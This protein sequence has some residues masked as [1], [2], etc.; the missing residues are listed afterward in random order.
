MPEDRRLHSRTLALALAGLLTL[1]VPVNAEPNP[2]KPT[3]PATR[4][5]PVTDTYHGEAVVDPFRWLEDGEAPEVKAWVAA[6]NAFTRRTIGEL[7]EREALRARLKALSGAPREGV[8]GRYGDRLFFTHHDGQAPQSRLLVEEKGTRRVLLDPNALSLDGTVSLDFW[9][10][11]PQGDLVAYG[12]SENGSEQSVGYVLDVLT[13]QKRPDVLPGCKYASLGWLPD[14]TGFY[15][16]RFTPDASPAGAETQKVYFHRLGTDPAK[17]PMLFSHPG[18][19]EVFLSLG[20][21]RD[22]RWVSVHVGKGKGNELHVLDREGT[23]GFQALATGF[24]SANYG[25]IH[26]GILYLRTTEGAPR[27]RLM[28]VELARPERAR[29][30]ELVAERE[31]VLQYA[32]LAG[33]RLVAEY[34]KDAR[35]EL[36]VFGLDGKGQG[37]I[38]LPGLGSV[39]SVSGKFEDDTLYF[40]Y[41][42]YLE[43]S[44]VYRYSLG[45]K[46]RAVRFRPSLA[47]DAAKYEERQVW[48]RSK[49]GTRVPMMLV[50]KKGLKP[51]GSNPT[52]LTAYGGFGIPMTPGFSSA[53][54][55]WVERGG[56]LAVPNLRGGGEFGDAWHEQGMLE[57][58]Q[59]VFD[60][61]HAAAEHLIAEC[62]TS[63][64][65]LGIEGG[66]NGGLLMGAALTQRPELYKAVVCAVPLLDMLRYHQFLIARFWVPEYGSSEDAAQYRYLKA[67]SPYHRV[68]AGTR[69]P[70]TLIVTGESDTRV[71][72]LHARKMAALLQRAQGGAAPVLLYVETKAGHGAGKPLDK[73]IETTADTLGFLGWQVGLK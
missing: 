50:H 55:A 35:S 61:F 52:L 30:T 24:E 44:S 36:A 10:P 26:A 27:G 46:E 59:N 29:W 71:D 57:R 70:A 64:A 69:Y 28:R 67:Y 40:S 43:P 17:D 13:G 20:I 21:S 6:Q 58:K 53:N 68:V 15:Y 2:A 45:T 18:G 16:T 3:Y 49:D 65:H 51:D 23:G 19:P 60:D 31:A 62:L 73:W 56:V 39:G 14:S 54:F 66:S 41:T 47:I 12:L 11:S 9:E 1:G 32:F 25:D 42:S 72:P 33:G 22:G 34:L 7:G 37:A 38:A 4:E 5:H 8:P 48:Y 63:P